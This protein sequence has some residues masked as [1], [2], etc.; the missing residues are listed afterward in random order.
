MLVRHQYQHSCQCIVSDDLYASS[1]CVTNGRLWST[2]ASL[3]PNVCVLQKE[4]NWFQRN[5]Q[6][7]G[8]G[9]IALDVSWMAHR[10]PMAGNCICILLEVEEKPPTPNSRAKK[11]N[12]RVYTPST[13]VVLPLCITRRESAIHRGGYLGRV[14]FRM[15]PLDAASQEHPNS[16]STDA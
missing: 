13:F 16:K 12:S 2:I 5:N 6:F 1:F 8:S 14:L 3:V 10:S 4:C 15:P 11:G 7:L 9:Q